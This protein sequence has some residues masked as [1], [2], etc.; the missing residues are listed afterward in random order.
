MQVSHWKRLLYKLQI[1]KVYDSFIT[2]IR[3]QNDKSFKLCEYSICSAAKGYTRLR[4]LKSEKAIGT[5]CFENLL[6]KQNCFYE[7]TPQV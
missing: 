3:Y 7:P 4:K 6:V 2:E 5:S 1:E